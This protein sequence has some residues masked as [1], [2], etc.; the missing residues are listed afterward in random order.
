MY[1]I[2]LNYYLPTASSV[3]PEARL[4]GAL[5]LMSLLYCKSDKAIWGRY[6]HKK[7]YEWLMVQRS[8]VVVSNSPCTIEEGQKYISNLRWNDWA[9][10]RN[11][12]QLFGYFTHFFEPNRIQSNVVSVCRRALSRLWELNRKDNISSVL[13]WG[14]G[15]KNE[16]FLWRWASTNIL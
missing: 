9:L 1:T 13:G 16:C 14:R 15:L 12:T 5:L 10:F 7:L 4:T 8:R 6:K 11:V 3:V 2:N